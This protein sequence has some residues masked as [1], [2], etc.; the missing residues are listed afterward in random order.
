MEMQTILGEKKMTDEQETRNS[1]IIA[2]DIAETERLKWQGRML[3][4]PSVMPLLPE[5]FDAHGKRIVDLACGAGEW[6]SMVAAKFPQSEVVGVDINESSIQYANE[7]SS[8]QENLEFTDMDILQ[9]LEFQDDTFDCVNVRLVFGVVPREYW[10]SFLAEIYR[11]LKPDGVVRLIEHAA[12]LLEGAPHGHEFLLKCSQALYNRGKTFSAYEAAVA[13]AL[14]RLVKSAGFVDIRPYMTY[15][16]Y[17]YGAPL[18]E[19][20]VDDFLQVLDRLQPLMMIDGKMSNEE[21][22]EMKVHVTDEMRSED[23]SAGWVMLRL[24]AKKPIA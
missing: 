4:K 3:S 20:I 19:M 11:I 12:S 13:P 6:A 9:P 2:N 24:Q 10:P 15:I 14:N 16:D 17:G 18:Y 7:M 23:W 22:Q 5:G 21:Y 8:G 1:Y